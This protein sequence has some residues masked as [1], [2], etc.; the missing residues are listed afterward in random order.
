M[1]NK[2]TSSVTMAEARTLCE[3]GGLVRE[4]F[5][6]RD[7][8]YVAAVPIE[9]VLCWWCREYHSPLEVETCMALE[10]PKPAENGQ[11]ASSW[12]AKIPSWLSQFPELWEFLSKPIYK[13]GTAR[14]LGK[15][16][17]GLNSAGIQMTLTDPSSSTYCSRNYQTIEDALLGF[18]VG[19]SDGSLTWRASGPLKGRKRP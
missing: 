15:V 18:E 17:F 10:R 13:D 1:L 2:R 14:Q 16:S 12:T 8:R 6:P 11:S 4:Y 5:T 9:R 3:L 7:G 19:L